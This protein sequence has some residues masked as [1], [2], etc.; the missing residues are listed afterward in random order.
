MSR[1]GRFGVEE[2]MASPVALAAKPAMGSTFRGAAL[3]AAP[4]CAGLRTHAV[5]PRTVMA[6]RTA[7]LKIT[8]RQLEVTDA[9]K[10]Y[11]EK[12]VENAVEHFEDLVKEVDV[13]LSVRTGGS[14]AHL[15]KAEITV[16]T[17]AGTLRAEEEAEILYGS[18]DLC[19]D[20][21][22]RKLRKM[23]EK[24]DAKHP[25]VKPSA[26]VVVDDVD[27]V[28]DL[29]DGKKAALPEEVVRTKYFHVPKLST[30]EAMEQM[31]LVDHDFYLFRNSETGVLNVL[32]ER[33]HGGYGLIVPLDE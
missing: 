28:G 20:K 16:Y 26:A 27:L 2:G 21:V 33:N 19:T 30:D 1:K 18:I 3:S 12:K 4:S 8:G 7:Q 5:P 31:Q 24:R 13:R 9:I 17:K 6:L 10:T 11:V 22:A 15:Q 23:K 25:H 14:S 32:Y 29:T